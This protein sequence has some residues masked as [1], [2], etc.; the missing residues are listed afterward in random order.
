MIHPDD[1][2]KVSESVIRSISE[3]GEHPRVEYRIKDAA[4]EWRWFES[5]GINLTG[6]PGIRGIVVSTYEVTERKRIKEALRESE[7]RFRSMVQSSSEVVKIV[8]PDGTLRYASPAYAEVLGYDPEDSVGTNVLDGVH[9]DD[10]PR[11][12][13]ETERALRERNGASG[14]LTSHAEYRYRHADGS[15]RDLESVGTYLLEDPAVSGVIVKLW[16]VTERKRAEE[17]LK[18][19]ERLR[20]A[21]TS[22]APIILF[23]LD[24]DGIFTLS[25]GRG[26]EALGLAPGEVVG[27]SVFDRHRDHPEILENNR[28][29]LTGEELV[30]TV[31]YG[32]LYF[33][34]RYSPLF[35]PEGEVEG[36]VCVATDVTGRKKAEEGMVLRDQAIAASVRG[37]IITG[38]NQED[39][40]IIYANPAF[41]QISGYSLE[42]MAGRNCRFLQNG[43]RDQEGLEG[44]AR[45]LEEGREWSCVMR[46]YKKDGTL[47][48]NELHV[49]PMRDGEGRIQN[50]VGI[51]QDVTEQRALQ[52][53]LAH[54]ATHDPLTDLPNRALLMDRL[55]HA[56]LRFERHG[57]SVAV[58]FLDL[59]GFKS[60]NDAFGHEGGDRL[61]SAVAGRLKAC[62]RPEDTVSRIGGDEFAVLLED[63]GPEGAAEAAERIIRELSRPFSTGEGT[64]REVRVTASIGIACQGAGDRSAGELLKEADRAM[65]RAKEGGGGYLHH[66]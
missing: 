18:A 34:T 55:S 36:A 19:S 26:L 27:Q 62:L 32:G 4:G 21:A 22:G 35:G 44:L 9:P 17:A 52:E 48:W 29:A 30:T 49:A 47:F 41:E 63:T 45:A 60:V 33:E 28:R 54:R 59:D 50:F 56:L 53:E 66:R 51:Q 57:E 64:A 37:I 2:A 40:P 24:R 15:W 43:D 16:D 10:L 3:P 25:E 65:Y 13:R 38:P 8:A 7:E 61:L 23:A 58:L 11:V 20:R 39:N 31:E 6:D 14:P 42:E 5:R 46:N 12:R 1:V